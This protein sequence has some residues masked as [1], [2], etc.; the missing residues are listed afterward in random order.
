MSRLK[1][2]AAIAC[3]VLATLPITSAAQDGDT[4][5][6]KIAALNWKQAPDKGDIA[7]KATIGLDGG[8]R[9]LDAP[10]TSEFLT[11]Q[12]NLPRPNTYTVAAKNLAWFS[13]FKFVDEGYVQDDEKIDADALLKALKENNVLASEERKKRNLPGLFLEG[14]FIPPRYDTDTKRLE[15]ATLL[16]TDSNEKVV[17]FSTKILGRRGHMDA[18]LVSDPQN[19]EADI[20]EFKGALKSFDY[21]PGERYSEWKKGEKI[22]AYG[23]GAL[24]LG[25]AAAVATKKG[26]WALL[27]G[28]LA[29]GWKVVAG[30]AVAAAAGIGSLFKKKDR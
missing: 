14:W 23:L 6:R 8:L 30:V 2:L 15:W 21:V 28:L 27:G 20:K 5:M 22:A 7:G 1:A 11:L 18:I 19:L 10:G 29:A 25:G 26:F 17:N 16:R 9:Y 13:V 4:M 24:V 12:G 3:I